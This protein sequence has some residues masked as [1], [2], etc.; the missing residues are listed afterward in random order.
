MFFNC[1]HVAHVMAVGGA[2]HVIKINV[3]VGINL[4]FKQR[5]TNF[6]DFNFENRHRRTSALHVFMSMLPAI[7]AVS[8]AVKPNTVVDDDVIGFITVTPLQR[9]Y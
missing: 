7:T 6:V 1:G 5:R 2:S 4:D 3:Y 9:V 8:A